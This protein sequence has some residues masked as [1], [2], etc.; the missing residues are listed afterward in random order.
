[1]GIKERDQILE[2]LKKSGVLFEHITHEPVFTSQQ[3]AEVRKAKLSEGVKAMVLQSNV[4]KL[5]LFCLPADQKID[6]KKAAA[7]AGAE[8]LSL[9]SP[10]DVLSATGCEIGSVSPFSGGLS[11]IPTF[12]DNGILQNV[13]VEFNIGLHTDSVRMKSKD[14][15][16]VVKPQLGLFSVPRV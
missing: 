6:L 8:R 12:F 5:F 16:E 4:K 1:M 13:S 10:A 2:W 15:V 14:L 7:L 3:A 11:E 9:A